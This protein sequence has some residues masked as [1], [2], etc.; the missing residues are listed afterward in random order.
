MSDSLLDK[1]NNLRKR[2]VELAEE[3][4]EAEKKKEEEKQELQK[5]LQDTIK[6]LL[7][8]EK[9]RFEESQK[10]DSIDNFLQ[11]NPEDR[12]F[13]NNQTKEAN[14]FDNSL[15]NSLKKVTDKPYDVWSQTE[16]NFVENVSYQLNK[17]K[18]TYSVEQ[19]LSMFRAEKLLKM[20]ED[21]KYRV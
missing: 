12:Q 21:K 19:D 7:L 9:K 8:E 15:Y 14:D 4:K 18:S 20:D 10:T 16:K 6:E 1:I 11:E 17:L 2:E 13:S 5:E 3:L